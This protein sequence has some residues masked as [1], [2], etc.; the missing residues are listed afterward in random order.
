MHLASQLFLTEGLR[1][2][3]PAKG[4]ALMLANPVCVSILAVCLLG[5]ALS[6]EQVIGGGVTLLGVFVAQR[7]APQ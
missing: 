6:L 1:E 5:E 3:G 2:A 4:S 7:T